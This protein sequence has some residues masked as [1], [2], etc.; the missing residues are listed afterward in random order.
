MNKP[1]NTKSIGV[2][3]IG[4]GFMGKAHAIA[5][6][7]AARIM[8]AMPEVSLE[9]LCDENQDRANAMA[10]QFGFSR[11]THHWRDVIDD[12]EVDLISITT[13]NALHKEMAIAALKA[14]KH[15]WC[16]KPMALTYADAKEMA[17]M[18]Q[19]TDAVTLAGYNYLRNPLIKHIQKL[20]DEG[21]IGKPV[22]FRGWVDEDYQADP[23]LP[24]TWRASRA[25]AGLGALGDLGCHLVSVMTL[26]MGP[27]TRLAA[28]AQ[29]IH[30]QR[31]MEQAPDQQGKTQFATVENEDCVTS[32][33]HFNSGAHGS[34]S[35]SRAAWGRKNRLDWEIHGTQGMI[36]FAQERMNEFKLYQNSGSPSEQ[37]FKTILAG[38]QHPPYG[39]FCPAPGHQLGFQDLKTIEA[40]ELLTS[41]EGTSCAYPNFAEA[42]DIENIIHTIDEAARQQ[43]WIDIR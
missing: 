18:A 35:A 21:A 38:P 32:L 23:D 17:A 9:M 27:V 43:R 29:I 12:P 1:K 40:F 20:L 25:Q 2:G 31:P 3:L 28:D 8:G 26:L 41:L 14:G 4:T 6:P 7:M 19:R 42:A 10:T 22:H 24:W 15:V 33:I 34:I 39:D 11:A 37:G 5:Y 13:P 16:E 30:N 36:T